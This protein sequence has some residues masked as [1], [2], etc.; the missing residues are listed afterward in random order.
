MMRQHLGILLVLIALGLAGA[1][2][3]FVVDHSVP[4]YRPHACTCH[5]THA[6]DDE[7]AADDAPELL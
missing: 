4:G 3:W 1:L 2:A 7:S 5:C 6:G